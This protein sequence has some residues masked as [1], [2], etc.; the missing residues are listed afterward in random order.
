MKKIDLAA[1]PTLVGSS[2]PR[3]LRR[4]LCGAPGA[5]ALGLAAGLTEF[6][7]NRLTLPPGAWSSQRH[8]H[9][10]EDEFIYVLEGEVRLIT[11][12]G[13]ETLRAPA[14]AP[15]SRPVTATAIIWSTG[16]PPKRWCWKSART[17]SN[18][19]AASIPTPT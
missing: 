2:Y 12:A 6:G 14:T 17:T 1:A 5:S 19:T 13:E 4:T 10:H 15:A 9:S 11:D 3:A 7:V 8:W 16:G 18:A